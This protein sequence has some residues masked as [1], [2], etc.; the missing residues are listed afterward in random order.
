MGFQSK[1]MI[2][3][4]WGVTCIQKRDREKRAAKTIFYISEWSAGFRPPAVA[5]DGWHL[6]DCR[7]ASL[8]SEYIE[9]SMV[10]MELESSLDGWRLGAGNRISHTTGWA[11]GRFVLLGD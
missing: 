4:F 8:S 2:G 5:R 3:Y 10:Q 1:D 7:G 9:P 6:F 11:I